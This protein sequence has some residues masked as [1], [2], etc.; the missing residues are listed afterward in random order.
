LKNKIKTTI[1]MTGGQIK[2]DAPAKTEKF[3]KVFPDGKIKEAAPVKEA[4]KEF[5]PPKKK[6]IIFKKPAKQQPKGQLGEKEG[7]IVSFIPVPDAT[8]LAI[9]TL[10]QKRIDIIQT[11]ANPVKKAIRRSGLEIKKAEELQERKKMAQEKEWEI[12]AFLRKI[13]FKS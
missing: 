6:K 11:P 12:P 8:A 7:G 3:A 10:E 9:P 4:K 1:L 2:E 5:K 13:K